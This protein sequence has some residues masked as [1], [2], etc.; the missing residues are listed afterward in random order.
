[1]RLDSTAAKLPANRPVSHMRA[2][3]AA[4]RGPAMDFDTLPNLQY[5]LDIKRKNF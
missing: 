1:M 4:S 2:L 5:V 3:L